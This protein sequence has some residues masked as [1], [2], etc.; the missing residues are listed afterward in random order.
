[1]L[2][3]FDRSRRRLPAIARWV[4]VNLDRV[5]LWLLA[6]GRSLRPYGNDAERWLRTSVTWVMR[7]TERPRHWVAMRARPILARLDGPLG[8]LAASGRWVLARVDRVQ[9]WMPDISRRAILGLLLVAQLAW[10]A[11]FHAVSAVA[12]QPAKAPTVSLPAPGLTPQVTPAAPAAAQPPKAAPTPVAVP[13]PAQLM[14]GGMPMDQ[15]TFIP[16]TEQ[17]GNAHAIITSGQQLNLPPRA[18]V[19]AVATSLQETSL[20]NYG[21]LGGANDHDSLGLFQQRPSSGWGTP[22]QLTDPHYASSAFYNALVQVPGWQNLPLTVAAQDVQV[23]AFGDRYAQWE[24]QA[25]DMVLAAYGI[26]PYW[27]VAAG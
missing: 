7:R 22:D 19:I 16:T 2:V 4:L 26:G 25:T 6:S 1:V 5:R 15:T 27:G 11:A 12:S 17:M 13:T 14:P 18:W 10:P 21:D 9:R 8:R 24:K 23:S 3:N 20:H